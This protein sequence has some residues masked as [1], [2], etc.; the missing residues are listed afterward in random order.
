MACYRIERSGRVFR[1]R[2]HLH[3]IHTRNL[4]RYFGKH[5]FTLADMMQGFQDIPAIHTAVL[6]VELGLSA[7][8]PDRTVIGA[9]QHS[10]NI[11]LAESVFSAERHNA[12]TP[13]FEPADKLFQC[14]GRVPEQGGQNISLEDI[15]HSFI[16]PVPA[17]RIFN[18]PEKVDVVTQFAKGNEGP[19]DIFP[20][21]YRAV[22][23]QQLRKI[24]RAG[25]RRG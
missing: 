22:S 21:L 20:R 18:K 6:E 2:I 15:G 12:G 7:H 19:T 16:L 3:V 25:V 17:F 1:C 23:G 8:R 13:F 14:Q 11:R 10:G 5:G 9:F 4:I 24:F